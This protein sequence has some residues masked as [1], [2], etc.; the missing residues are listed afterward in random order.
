MREKSKEVIVHVCE[1]GNRDI[2]RKR[3]R[4]REGEGERLRVCA[5]P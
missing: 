1:R 2:V 5:W 4:E 3:E